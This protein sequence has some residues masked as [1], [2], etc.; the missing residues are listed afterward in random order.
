MWNAAHERV[1]PD[2]L[3]EKIRAHPSYKDGQHVVLMSC[4]TGKGEAPFAQHLANELNAPVSA[5]DNFLWI[6]PDG[7]TVPMGMTPDRKMVPT[8]PGKWR[9]FKPL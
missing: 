9:T 4:N 2:Q 1:E 8:D 6:W 5:P 7:K 3:A